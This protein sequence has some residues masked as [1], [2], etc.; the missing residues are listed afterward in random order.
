[1][2]NTTDISGEEW[3]RLEQYLLG[4]MPPGEREA[5]DEKLS[6]DPELQA[7]LS[8][9]RRLLQGVAEAVLHN[10]LQAFH[11]GI[12]EN[13][14]RIGRRSSPLRTWLIAASILV[15]AGAAGWFLLVGSSR[16]DK[17]FA[18]YFK[19]DPGLI[20]AMSATDNYAFEKAMIDYKKGD[21]A[22]AIEAWD[23]LQKKAPANDTLRYFLGVA[24]LANKRPAEAIPYL[25]K[26]AAT[27]GFFRADARWYLALALLK[28]GKKESALQQLEGAEHP[29][30]AELLQALRH[31]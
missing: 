28:E 25:E 19:P 18:A 21:Y 8:A 15:V 24:H 5:F 12:P 17:L 9:V 30:K 20:T 2:D 14:P 16:H 11:E 13:I 22:A 1:V 23:S 10:K 3:E 27:P 31:D 26:A 6:N 4:E 29:R 7:Q